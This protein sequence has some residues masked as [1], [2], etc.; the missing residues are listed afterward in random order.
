[1]PHPPHSPDLAPS[2]FFLFGSVKRKLVG[3]RAESESGLL[4]RIHVIFAE[5]PG[6]ILNA[7]LFEWMDRLQKCI[8]TNGDYGA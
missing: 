3:Y 5:I 1:M 7:V 4:V 6:E 8:D 2:D